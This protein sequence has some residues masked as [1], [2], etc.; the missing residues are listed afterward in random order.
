MHAQEQ[1]PDPAH[2][3]MRSRKRRN[4]LLI[5][6]LLAP[7]FAGL[8]AAGTQRPQQQHHS[9]GLSAAAPRWTPKSGAGIADAAAVAARAVLCCFL[10]LLLLLLVK[11]CPPAPQLVE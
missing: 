5:C 8:W 3:T 9:R 2:R 6:S 1:Q 10:P 11:S 7:L 4:F